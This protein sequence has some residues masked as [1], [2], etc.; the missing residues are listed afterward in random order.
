MHVSLE[1]PDDIAGHLLENGGDLSRRALEGLALEEFK[2]G[3]ITKPELRRLLGFGTRYELDGFL[4]QH[5]VFEDYGI[6]DFEK[7]REALKALGL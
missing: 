7:E 5:E 2:R 4:K 3:R 6:E 1:I